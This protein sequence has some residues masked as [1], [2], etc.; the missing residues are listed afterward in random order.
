[1]RR[2]RL[3]ALTVPSLLT[4]ASAGFAASGLDAAWNDCILSTSAAYN[5]EFAC[6]TNSG[7][8]RIFVSFIAPPEATQLGQIA[9]Q[10]EI[11]S[12][13]PT[14]P[15]WWDF[16][17]AGC[18]GQGLILNGD[19]TGMSACDNSAW[20]ASTT[21]GAAIVSPD[22]AYPN[23]MICRNLIAVPH[24]TE[25]LLTA[26]VEYYAFHLD[27]SHAG[28][29]GL[30]ACSGCNVPVCI[31]FD[32]LDL[33]LSAGDPTPASHVS[34]PAVR[35]SVIWQGSGAPSLC[36]NAYPEPVAARNRTWSA[37]RMLYR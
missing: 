1:M 35:G 19:F 10:F 18:R 14:F 9:T 8:D 29:V 32:Y 23:R 28:T 17:S 15:S 26:D 30:G 27:I 12:A 6:D 22:P 31:R 20:G 34:I 4:I 25:A 2:L 11:F 5:R 13:S 16:R 21:S 24:S 36:D 3:L 7:V 37:I 33:Y